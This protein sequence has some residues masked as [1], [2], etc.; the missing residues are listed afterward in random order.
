VDD[1]GIDLPPAEEIV[2]R[3]D[4]G[5]EL[6]ARYQTLQRALLQRIKADRFSANAGKLFGQ[7][8]EL[9]SYLDRATADVG[10]TE[11]G[12]YQ[13]RYPDGSV[14]AEHTGLPAETLL[15][16]EAWLVDVVRRELAEGRNVMVFPWHTQLMPRIARMLEAA[17]GEKAPILW[18]EKVAPKKREDWINKEVVSKGRRLLIVNPVAVQTGLNNLVHFATEVWLENPACNPLIR[19]QAIGRVRRIG[20]QLQTRIYT[21][22]YKGTMQEVLHKLLLHKVGVSEAADGL[23]ATA[24]LQAAGVGA[25]DELAGRDLGRMLYEMLTRG[26]EDQAAPTGQQA[27]LGRAK[28]AQASLGW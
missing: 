26:D 4:P 15:P 20:Q 5:P 16:K 19:R 13:I 18:A 14:V 22:V 25:A 7:L 28:P 9:P 10:N 2:E 1:L 11:G 12:A 17:T 27:R 3:V 21:P 24:A 8:A 23:D 6:G